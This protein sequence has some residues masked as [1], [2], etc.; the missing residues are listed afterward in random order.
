MTFVNKAIDN[1]TCFFIMR[2]FDVIDELIGVG[3]SLFQLNNFNIM[4]NVAHIYQSASNQVF[5]AMIFIIETLIFR[6]DLRNFFD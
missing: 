3:S 1:L 5:C 4:R 2:A 6:H